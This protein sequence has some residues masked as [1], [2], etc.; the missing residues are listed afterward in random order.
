MTRLAVKNAWPVLVAAY[1]SPPTDAS[2]HQ[3]PR[4]ERSDEGHSKRTGPPAIS[5]TRD[6]ILCTSSS[7]ARAVRPELGLEAGTPISSPSRIPTKI[8]SSA[9]LCLHMYYRRACDFLTGS[10]D[11]P[12]SSSAARSRPRARWSATS[13][14]SSSRLGARRSDALTDLSR[15]AARSARDP[16]PRA[17]RWP[18]TA[19]SGESPPPRGHTDRSNR[20][21]SGESSGTVRGSPFDAPACDPDQ[22]TNR[23]SLAGVVALFVTDRSLEGLTRNVLG[24]RPVSNAVGDVRVDAAD[25]VRAGERVS[26]KH[27]IAPSR[28][29]L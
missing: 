16:A 8:L 6:S 1:L 22:P 7:L 5:R 12:A 10:F 26:A 13:I 25:S 11:S 21:W 20:E 17:G 29:V 24:V 15:S 3:H 14:A 27:C 4:N 23:L 2:R 18:S 9:G 19:R 28:S